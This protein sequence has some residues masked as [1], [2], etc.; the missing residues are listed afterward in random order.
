MTGRRQAARTLVGAVVG[1]VVGLV[2]LAGCATSSPDAGPTRASSASRT[3]DDLTGTLTVFAAASLTGAFDELTARFAAEHPGVDVQPVTYDGSS[4]LATQLVEGARADVFASA[5]EDTMATVDDAGLVEGAP[6][7]FTTNTLQIVVPA[8]NPDRVASVA[9]LAALASS[10]GRVVLCAAQVPC[11]AASQKVVES[12]GVSLTP[13]S[14]EQNVTAVLTKVAAGEADAGLVYRTD[15]LAA[16]DDVE[17]VDVDEAADVV[18]RYPIAV[19]GT[20]DRA[21]QDA[22]VAQAFVDLVLSDTGQRVLADRGF[23]AP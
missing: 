12:A 5:D 8:G 9:D 15:V 19:L 6:T 21:S 23:V 11:G 18:N 10:G 13:A 20:G 7:V 16:G 4:T 3:G 17:G 14:E 2:V 1:A 22:A